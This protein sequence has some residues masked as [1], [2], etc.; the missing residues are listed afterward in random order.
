MSDEQDS[1]DESLKDL[2]KKPI[3]P[4][5]AAKV[6]GGFLTDPPDTKLIDAPDTRIQS[7]NLRTDVR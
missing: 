6:K 7:P 4:A 1:H 5:E 3:D 2:E